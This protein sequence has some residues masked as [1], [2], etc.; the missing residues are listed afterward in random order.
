MNLFKK[1]RKNETTEVSDTGYVS[2]LASNAE[3][4]EET[5]GRDVAASAA[6]T[7]GGGIKFISGIVAFALLIVAATYAILSATLMFTTPHNGQQMDR[8]WVARG[9]FEGGNVNEGTTI[10]ASASSTSPK[11]FL[12][13][14]A[15]GFVSPADP[16]IAKVIAGPIA[17][18][19]SKKNIIYIN[20]KKTAYEGTIENTKLINKYLAVCIDSASCEANTYIVIDK[21][22]ISGEVRGFV[23]LSG[24]REI[25]E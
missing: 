9:T 1:F 8:V 11:N 14:M 24:V 5:S 3:I 16:V 12:N 2:P 18:V 7:L 15:E 22:S 21:D 19:S 17:E 10:L 25:N 20:D 13:K 4:M 6:R 23:S